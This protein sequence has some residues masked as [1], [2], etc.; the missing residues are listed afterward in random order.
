MIRR[1][2]ETG[3]RPEGP[4]VFLHQVLVLRPA[5]VF[6]LQRP[7]TA[8]ITYFKLFLKKK[9]PNDSIE[10]IQMSN[11]EITHPSKIV[12]SVNSC[13][14]FHVRSH[15]MIAV[16]NLLIENLNVNVLIY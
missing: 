8:K 7:P 4:V 11:S 16:F 1:S 9:R 10:K 5:E 13:C 3:V 12:S 2:K 14:V 15:Q 6:E